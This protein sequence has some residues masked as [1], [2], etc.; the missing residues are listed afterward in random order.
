MRKT[1]TK[2]KE[3]K[4]IRKLDKILELLPT[5]LWV[6]IIAYFSHKER[7]DFRL[8]SIQ[9]NEFYNSYF[10]VKFNYA[11]KRPDHRIQFLEE[12]NGDYDIVN[13]SL[14]PLLKTSEPTEY[15]HLLLTGNS[16]LSVDGLPDSI[17]NLVE[18]Y[19]RSN[20]EKPGEWARLENES[21]C[22]PGCIVATWI[23]LIVLATGCTSIGCFILP[24]LAR[25]MLL[26]LADKIGG[27]VEDFYQ[28]IPL[29]PIFVNVAIAGAAGA[30]ACLLTSLCGLCIVPRILRCLAT[31]KKAFL[32]EPLN[33]FKKG[34]FDTLALVPEPLSEDE[35]EHD[36]NH[37]SDDSDIIM[38]A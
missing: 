36:D 11:Q 5:E 29:Y 14:V 25:G 33:T 12:N 26:V 37:L 16:V 38:F 23:G 34:L 2:N 19:R 28:A 13:D 10:L 30:A 9:F 15:T 18:K 24:I 6:C 27:G 4:K 21:G 20:G 3:L 17:N 35:D 32:A 8:V 7:A 31:E 22:L 1:H